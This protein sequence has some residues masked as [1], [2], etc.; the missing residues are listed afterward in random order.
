M[1]INFLISH[2][3]YLFQAINIFNV[4]GE[5]SN[6]CFSFIKNANGKILHQMFI[7]RVKG[8][9]TKFFDSAETFV[10]HSDSYD[11]I[12]VGAPPS[13]LNKIKNCYVDCITR[14]VIVTFFPG[15]LQEKKIEGLCNRSSVDLLLLNSKKDLACYKI[16]GKEFG[17]DTSNGLCVGF[18]NHGKGQHGP[19]S[20]VRF[21]EKGHDILFVEQPVIPNTLIDRLRLMDELVDL[22]NRVSCQVNIK[23]RSAIGGTQPI[24]KAKFH[25]EEIYR[26]YQNKGLVPSNLTLV[27]EDMDRL[28]ERTKLCVSVS[29]TALFRAMV[30]GIPV[31]VVSDFGVKDHFGNSFFMGSG[32]YG[33]LSEIDEY[34]GNFPS[35]NWMQD[36]YN[37]YDIESANICKSISESGK[38][39]IQNNKCKNK[40]ISVNIASYLACMLWV[41]LINQ[42]NKF[43]KSD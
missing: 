20:D 27:F 24:A 11:A 6:V 19:A 2:D 40:K 22:A 1:N 42:F 39:K 21:R 30:R 35:I 31:V 5:A 9:K 16:A 29:S 7:D 37:F 10:L 32:C 17:F 26:I 33:L 13:I 8:V 4:M 12:V 14:P 3:S 25:I 43:F 34:S 41:R 36:N 15:I 38:R 18:L 28:L 23:A